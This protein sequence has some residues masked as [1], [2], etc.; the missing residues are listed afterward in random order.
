MSWDL[1]DES[2][3]TLKSKLKMRWGKITN[4][5]L[6]A[7]AGKREKLLEVIKQAY[8]LSEEDAD[9]QIKSFEAQTKELRA[10]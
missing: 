2:W 6:E 7:I 1:S 10:K 3:N 4:T 8:G 5:H 9:T